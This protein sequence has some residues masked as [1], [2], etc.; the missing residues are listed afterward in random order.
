M[1]SSQFICSGK[2]TIPYTLSV[3][4]GLRVEKRKRNLKIINGRFCVFYRVLLH[5]D[6]GI[7]QNPNV[8]QTC[9][10]LHASGNHSPFLLAFLI[11]MYEEKIERGD[12]DKADS[13]QH[14]IQVH[15]FILNILKC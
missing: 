6:G 4:L 5:H 12:G 1:A 10:E 8:R 9:E 14:A 13:L 3:F 11:D 15:Y 2:S 7:C